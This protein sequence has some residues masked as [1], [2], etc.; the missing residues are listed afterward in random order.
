MWLRRNIRQV[1]QQGGPEGETETVWAADEVYFRAAITAGEVSERFD[2][3]FDDPPVPPPVYP[4]P[5]ILERVEGLE[6]AMLEIAGTMYG[7]LGVS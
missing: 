2:E 4:A 3:L 5:T 6:A 7:D 1:E